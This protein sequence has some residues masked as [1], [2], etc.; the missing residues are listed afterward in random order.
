MAKPLSEYKP[1]YLIYGDQDLLL[2]RQ[3]DKLKRDVGELVDLEFNSQTFDGD[4]ATGDDVVAACNTFPFASERRLVVVRNVEKMNKDDSEALVRYAEN[5]AETTILALVA[6][7]LAKNTR[8]YKAVD[9]IGGLIERAA[10]KPSEY[11]GEVRN[12]FARK[13]KSVTLEGAELLVNA[14]GKDLRRLS[15]EV[16]KAIAFTGGKVDLTA[17]DIEQVVSTTATTQVWELGTALGERDCSRALQ[18]LDRLLG[19]GESVHGLHALSLRHVR[20]LIAAR[21]LIDRGGGSVGE[22]ASTLGRPDWQI[23]NLPKQARGFTSEELVDILRAAAVGEA[24]MKTS[25]DPR[26]VFERW[27]VKVCG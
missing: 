20:D 25:R 7:K 2:E 19:D 12:L 21:A 9:K 22:L 15:V 17:E 14:V 16:D 27:I 13:G 6:K 26:L 18:L 10:P 11:P 1:V 8:L 5:P 23:R 3:L 4:S 24:Q